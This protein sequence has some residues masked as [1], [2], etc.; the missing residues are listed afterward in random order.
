MAMIA[1]GTGFSNVP[2]EHFY[3]TNVLLGKI[4]E[5]LY[6]FLPDYPWYGYYIIF[7]HFISNVILLYALLKYK[8]SW[9]RFSFFVFYFVA[10]QMYFLMNL[11][12]TTT[13]FIAGQS[14]VFLFFAVVN[15][16]KSTDTNMLSHDTPHPSLPLKG[17]G[18][19]RGWG[20]YFIGAMLLLLSALIRINS[21]YLILILSVPLFSINIMKHSNKKILTEYLIFLLSV[22]ILSAAAQGYNKYYYKQDKDWNDFYERINLIA[23]N[24]IDNKNAVYNME[25]K[26]IFDKAN[27]SVNDFLMLR[28]CFYADPE[29]YGKQ[30]LEQILS[31]FKPYKYYMTKKSFFNA[32]IDI[33][34]NKV[35]WTI[36]FV[37]LIFVSYSNNKR[38]IFPKIVLTAILVGTLIIYLIIFKKVPER[39]YLPMFSFIAFISL[40]HIDGSIGFSGKL[41]GK[42]FRDSIRMILPVIGFLSLLS[43]LNGYYKEG[44]LNDLKNQ[45]IKQAIKNLNPTPDKVFVVWGTNFPYE[46]FS[47]FDNLNIYFSKFNILTTVSNNPI[48][49]EMM[50][51]FGINDIYRSLY[52]QKNVFLISNILCNSLFRQYVKEHY[53]RDIEFVPY[54]DS[55]IFQ[56][57][58]A[59]I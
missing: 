44:Q 17:G 40:F 46:F 19:G 28:S 27:W 20:L 1:S 48:N 32:F 33:F 38:N 56:V 29:L 49:A 51:E 39:A 58:K 15:R 16:E 14:G 41:F 6:S 57:Y 23:L 5:N 36:L 53:F 18:L 22:F 3:M 9:T 4:L 34:Q 30:K 35:V 52:E 21:F 31:N 59:V 24:F 10:I 26:H 25:T 54:Y 37:L 8:F 50:K 7:V 45:A 47:P 11:Q 42:T 55:D 43:V 13:A 12:F 2:D